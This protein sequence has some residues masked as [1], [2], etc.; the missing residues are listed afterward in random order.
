[1]VIY[2]ILKE[3]VMDKN[4]LKY[5]VK[6]SLIAM[7]ISIIYIILRIYIL[8]LN[9][10][11]EIFYNDKLI[12]IDILGVSAIITSLYEFIINI[13]LYLKNK[14]NE[15]IIIDKN[16][17]SRLEILA[18]VI[19]L[20]PA[21]IIFLVSKSFS[22]IL[23]IILGIIIICF[24]IVFFISNKKIRLILFDSTLILYLALM[25][26]YFINVFLFKEHTINKTPI[27][28]SVSI[29]DLYE[30]PQ[31]VKEVEYENS[32]GIFASYIENYILFTDSYNINNYVWYSELQ[33]KNKYIFN[34]IKRNN[35][36][37]SGYQIINNSFNV[38]VDY[39]EENDNCYYIQ[40]DNTIITLETN[41]HLTENDINSII[42]QINNEL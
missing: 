14:N 33:C 28:Q 37:L 19:S 4:I 6:I 31:N 12:L 13:I 2:V 22:K 17:F 27:T 29:L 24:I 25:S 3:I 35:T 40:F 38:Y 11:Y 1:M 36:V 42:I 41:I 8:N 10:T 34:I 16:L 39:K 30:N 15:K 18:V 21:W 5:R 7:I 32:S 23:T 9:A 26:P 20:F